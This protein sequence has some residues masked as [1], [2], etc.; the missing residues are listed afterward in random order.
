MYIYQLTWKMCLF[1]VLIILFGGC[2]NKTSDK[3]SWPASLLLMPDGLKETQVPDPTS[4]G[5]KL[6]IMYC[7]QC[8]GIPYPA[9]HSASDWVVIMRKMMLLTQQS[10]NMSSNGGMMR[11]M[12]GR[13]NMPMGMVGAKMPTQGEQQEI[14]SYLQANSLKTIQENELPDLSSTIAGEFKNKC[15][16]CHA[17][18]SPF[19]HTAEQWPD[20]VDRMRKHMKELKIAELTDD[21]A[22]SITKYL[23]NAVQNK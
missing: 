12:M 20:V 11:G 3:S 7:S 19:Q 18:P 15:A 10:Y 9:G 4:D 6:T 14:L 8:H 13:R 22:N 5:A 2:Q 21:E 16:I 1:T 17:L 23:Q